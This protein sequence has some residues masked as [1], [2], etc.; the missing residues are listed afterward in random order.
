MNRSGAGTG[1]NNDVALSLFFLTDLVKEG[2]GKVHSGY[3]KRSPPLSS[4]F[5]QSATYWHSIRFGRVHLTDVA[6]LNDLLHFR[7]Q[8]WYPPVFSQARHRV[9]HTK[10]HDLIVDVKDEL[11][12]KYT[13]R[14]VNRL[15]SFNSTFTPENSCTV[16]FDELP[17]WGLQTCFLC[18]LNSLHP[19]AVVISSVTNGPDIFFDLLLTLQ[20]LIKRNTHA[21]TLIVRQ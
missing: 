9:P 6:V 17:S 16:I 1:E 18:F 14:K 15:I 4:I 3:F 20:F 11:L 19:L 13:T 7:S 10:M 5:W 8:L 21:V 2:S 12:H